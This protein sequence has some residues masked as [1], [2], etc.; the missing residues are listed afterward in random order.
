[1]DVEATVLNAVRQRTDTI[2][3]R[4]YVESKNKIKYGEQTG[5][6]QGNGMRVSKMAEGGQKAQTSRDKRTSPRGCRVWHGEY[7]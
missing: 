2:W 1:M 4:L 6:C 5:G 7:S 3:F